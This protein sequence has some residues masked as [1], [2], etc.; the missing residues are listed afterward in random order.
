LFA[1]NQILVAT[2]RNQAKFG[3]ITS[4]TEKYYFRWTDPYPMIVD[5]LQHGLSSPND[6]QK[7][8][9]GMFAPQMYVLCISF[10]MIFV[11]NKRGAVHH[12]GTNSLILSVYK[13][14]E[15]YNRKIKG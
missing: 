3:T 5:E 2:C 4:Y 8:I 6:Q 10:I 13:R 14:G 1:Y 7:L 15:K 9:A 12:D 11:S